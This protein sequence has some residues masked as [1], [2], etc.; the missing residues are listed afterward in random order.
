MVTDQTKDLLRQLRS[1]TLD[2]AATNALER[3]SAANLVAELRTAYPV[4][5]Q[6]RQVG[7]K[8]EVG[9]A[10]VLQFEVVAR[11]T[12]GSRF[13]SVI[14]L[15]VLRRCVFVS[16]YDDRVTELTLAGGVHVV[17]GRE[18]TGKV[19]LKT[20]AGFKLDRTPDGWVLNPLKKRSVTLTEDF[21]SKRGWRFEVFSPF[22]RSPVP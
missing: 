18:T 6:E 2:A 20:G 13:P 8:Y 3:L 11:T 17:P 7:R 14:M 5:F 12:H 10:R 16:A 4:V 9:L 22:F 19:V 15:P 21:L 1:G